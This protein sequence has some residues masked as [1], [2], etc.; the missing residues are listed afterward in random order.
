[1][2]IAASSAREARARAPL[3]RTP[4]LTRPACHYNNA[5]AGPAVITPCRAEPLRLSKHC[6]QHWGCARGEFVQGAPRATLASESRLEKRQKTVHCAKDSAGKQRRQAR[7]CVFV[8]VCCLPACD[9]RGGWKFVCLDFPCCS[10]VAVPLAS[11]PALRDDGACS[12][13][14]TASPPHRVA[15]KRQTGARG[16]GTAHRARFPAAARSKLQARRRP[17][18][19]SRTFPTPGCAGMRRRCV[20]STPAR[21]GPDTCARSLACATPA[22]KTK[23]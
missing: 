20:A 1:M 7:A 17:A 11:P 9:R 22:I 10:R 19:A 14:V 13:C 3:T 21:T 6:I 16:G 2:V 23:S 15:A 12:R 4:P 18:L 8:A 5:P